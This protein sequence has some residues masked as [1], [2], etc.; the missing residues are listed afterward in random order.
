MSLIDVVGGGNYLAVIKN[1]ASDH[2]TSF[3]HNLCRAY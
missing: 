1:F 2:G 3:D